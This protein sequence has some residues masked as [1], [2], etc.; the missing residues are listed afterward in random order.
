MTPATAE[1]VYD[2]VVKPLPLQERLKLATI[3]L[4]GIPP[5]AVVDYSEA[6]SEQDVRDFASASWNHV[7]QGV[8]EDEACTLPPSSGSISA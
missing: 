7:L 6:W 3:I 4:N 8:E 2:Q 1:E 5:Q